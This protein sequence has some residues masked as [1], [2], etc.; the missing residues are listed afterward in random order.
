ML[1]PVLEREVE[2]RSD[3]VVLAKVDVDAN[4]TVATTYRVSGIPAVKA[5]RNGNVAAEFVGARPPAAVAEFLDSLLDRR[6]RGASW[7]AARDRRAMAEAPRAIEAEDYERGARAPAG[8]RRRTAE[9]RCV[10]S[11]AA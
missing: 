8:G 1:A 2:S 7:I 6:P 4:P 9:G 11:S 3:R 10:S 5:F